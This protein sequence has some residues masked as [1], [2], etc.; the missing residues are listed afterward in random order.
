MQEL[1]G[2]ATTLENYVI[3]FENEAV[4]FSH[5]GHGNPALGTP[6]A[7]KVKHSIYYSGVH[8]FGASFEFAYEPGPITNLALVLVGDGKWRFVISEG[9]LLPFPPR[10]IS[11]PQT[12]FRHDTL[13][14][15]DWCDA[16]LRAGATHHMGAARGR[17]T[18]QLLHLARMLGIE[19]VVV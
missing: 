18:A 11:A 12:L 13:P 10:P 5:D 3:D 15:A 9:Q 16:W 8:G 14:I 19:A 2:Q 1:A 17:W 4:M 6:G 7:V